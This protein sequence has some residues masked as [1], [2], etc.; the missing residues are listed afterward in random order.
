MSVASKILSASANPSDKKRVLT[1]ANSDYLQVNESVNWVNLSDVDI[2]IKIDADYLGT[3]TEVIFAKGAFS[4]VNTGDFNITKSSV[5]FIQ[6]TTSDISNVN[7]S[8]YYPAITNG[9]HTI[10]IKNLEVFIDGVLS[11]TMIDQ[12][13]NLSMTLYKAVVGTYAHVKQ[14]FIDGEIHSLLLEDSTVN[15]NEGNGFISK[16]DD[17]IITATGNTSAA[18]PVNYWNQNVIKPI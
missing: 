7:R 4:D 13:I 17:G 11:L 15:L 16:S 5:G 18:D 3:G 9:L 2:E 10:K 14:S 1:A 6:I 12:S 8:F